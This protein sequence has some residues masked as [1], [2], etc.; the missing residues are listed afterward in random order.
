M[1]VAI[2]LALAL[3]GANGFGLQADQ[4]ALLNRRHSSAGTG[5]DLPVC[6]K[7]ASSDDNVDASLADG[8]SLSRRN[9]LALCGFSAVAS[10]ASPQ[11]ASAIDFQVPN[12]P[13]LANGSNKQRVGGFASKIRQSSNIMVR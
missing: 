13:G 11:D 7:S 5:T 1:R 12:M 2:L 6:L 10:V 8:D 9:L 4:D 3:E